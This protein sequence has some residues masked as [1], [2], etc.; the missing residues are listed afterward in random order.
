MAYTGPPVVCERCGASF[1]RPSSLRRHLAQRRCP[2]RAIVAVKQKPTRATPPV[3]VPVKPIHAETRAVS[4]HVS[5]S[6]PIRQEARIVLAKPRHIAG[7]TD[8]PLSCRGVQ[9]DVPD[10]VL[11]WSQYHALK[12]LATR[13]DAGIGTERET[14]GF[15]AALAEY[16]R[17]FER[18]RAERH[19][20]EG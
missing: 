17:N 5:L 14:A 3:L 18:V 9:T 7:F 4:A 12:A 16:N 13:L 15:Y 1:S 10:R 2:G 8:S 6:K 11:L 19:A 20:L